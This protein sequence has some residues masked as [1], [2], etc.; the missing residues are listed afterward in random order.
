MWDLQEFEH[1]GVKKLLFS[2]TLLLVYTQ[3]LCSMTQQNVQQA[4]HRELRTDALLSHDLITMPRRTCMQSQSM[5]SGT[6]AMAQDEDDGNAVLFVKGAPGVIR[7]MADPATV[8]ENYFQARLLI[9]VQLLCSS[10]AHACCKAA[11]A[12]LSTVLLM[13]TSSTRLQCACCLASWAMLRQQVNIVS[14]CSYFC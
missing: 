14:R 12:A 3:L 6:I 13:A 11:D 1:S 7:Q 9:T 5:K 8:P 2:F 4:G 10:A